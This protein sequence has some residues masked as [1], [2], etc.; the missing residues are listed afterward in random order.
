MTQIRRNGDESRLRRRTPRR[1]PIIRNRF[2]CVLSFLV[3]VNILELLSLFLSNTEELSLLNSVQTLVSYSFLST[4]TVPSSDSQRRYF[5][6]EKSKRTNVKNTIIRHQDF[7]ESTILLPNNSSSTDDKTSPASVS[8]G[9]THHN[10]NNSNATRNSPDYYM[11]F[12]TSCS[13]Q[14]HWQSYVFFYHANKVQ[15]PGSVVRT[16]FYGSLVSIGNVCI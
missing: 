3:L 14:Q 6:M 15:Q 4:E 9:D 8:T 2:C 5:V 11:V 13:A 1:R 16:L 10:N 12:S 7:E